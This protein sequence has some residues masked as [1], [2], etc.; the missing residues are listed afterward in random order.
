[1]PTYPAALSDSETRRFWKHVRIGPGCWEW[2]ASRKPA[3]YGELRVRGV[4]LYAHRL[5]WLISYGTLPAELCV[6]HRCDNPPCVRP[7]HL[8]LGTDNENHR[9]MRAKG[10]D[11]KPPRFVGSGHPMARIDEATARLVWRLW[12]AGLSRAQIRTRTGVPPT[13]VYMITSR[14]QWRHITE[15]HNAER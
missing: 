13:T 4:N 9:D 8:F 7:D 6:L 1:M 3:G 11:S 14:R 10:R 12:C 5:S 15:D 2:T